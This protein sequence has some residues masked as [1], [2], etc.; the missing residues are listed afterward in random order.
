MEKSLIYV[1]SLV[2]SAPGNRIKQEE[3]TDKVLKDISQ[4]KGAYIGYSESYRMTRFNKDISELVSKGFL[5]RIDDVLEMSYEAVN[6]FDKLPKPFEGAKEAIQTRLYELLN[7]GQALKLDI[8]R[9][10]IEETDDVRDGLKS[11]MWSEKPS[12]QHFSS[13]QWTR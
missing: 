1:M 9:L 12:K 3:L 11:L 8:L 5:R 2:R 10:I 13:F 6:F 4:N 7:T